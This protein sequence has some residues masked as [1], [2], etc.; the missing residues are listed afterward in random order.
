MEHV[1]LLFQLLALSFSICVVRVRLAFERKL[2]DR[3]LRRLL[4]EMRISRLILP[5]RVFVKVITS[6]QVDSQSIHWLIRPS[7]WLPLSWICLSSKLILGSSPQVHLISTINDRVLFL[8]IERL[9]VALNRSSLD[10]PVEICGILGS[11]VGGV[12][13]AD[14]SVCNSSL[15]LFGVAR[16][17]GVVGV[18]S[19][20]I[21]QVHADNVRFFV[22]LP[23]TAAESTS[24]AVVGVTRSFVKIICSSSI[25]EDGLRPEINSFLCDYGSLLYF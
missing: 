24:Q 22:L 11:L 12:R 1:L 16:V 8:E 20:F 3:V 5:V 14:E 19:H 7:P 25:L 15:F 23:V 9:L 4:N 17:H 21:S 18:S 13:I 2:V 6:Q 10:L